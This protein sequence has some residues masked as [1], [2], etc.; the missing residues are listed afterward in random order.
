MNRS[1]FSIPLLMILGAASMTGC[2]SASGDS[3]SAPSTSSGSGVPEGPGAV[4]ISQGGAQ[5]FGLFRQILEAGQIPG[6]ETLDDVGFFSEHKLDYPTPECG[7]DVCMH[8]LVGM[9]G[10]M[11]TGANCTLLQVGLNSPVDVA[12]LERPPMHLVLSVDISGSM[13]GQPIAYL[14][15]G[16]VR[17]VS[18]LGPKDRVSLVTF[19]DKAEVVLEA[20]PAAQ[21]ETLKAAFEGLAVKGATNLYDGLFTA[22]SLTEKHRQAG[23]QPRVIFLSDGEATAGLTSAA[24]VRSLAASYAK[25]GTPI[26]SVG[27]GT[28]FD[29]ELMRALG[30]VGAGNFYFLEDPS[31][32]VEVFAEEV[33]TFLYPVAL[34]VT[35]EAQVGS[36]YELRGVYGTKNW[37]SGGGLA[38]VSIPS[39]FL[40]GRTKASEPIEGGRRGGGG[41][42][43]VEVIPR[44]NEPAA[45][46]AVGSLAITWKKPGTGDTVSQV[47]DL[48]APFTSQTVPAQGYFTS[49][50]SEKGFVMLNLFAGFQLAARSARD[51]DARG[52]D[53]TL[54]PLETSV[55]AW[56]QKSPDPD[57]E[58]DLKYLRLFRKNLGKLQDYK[59]LPPPLPQNPW[60]ND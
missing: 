29:V 54:G 14:R 3:A 5:D 44:G 45:E 48:S 50:T 16:L 8:G 49:F 4:G 27:V 51:G 55:L 37:E 17:M 15:E 12:S 46:T 53:A 38:T 59:Q 18:E 56:L 36:A 43:L 28:Q 9:M 1:L 20:V 22:L 34:D 19:S 32:V 6:P 23:E 35:I 11:I 52:A 39:L 26:S 7:N 57:I 21:G 42:I 33:A 30:E 47:I 31:A 60:P 25:Q 58:D 13:S 40:A 2:G 41:A 24:K 10:N